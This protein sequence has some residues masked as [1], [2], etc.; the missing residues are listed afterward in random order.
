MYKTTELYMLESMVDKL[1]LI[2]EYNKKINALYD[3]LHDLALATDNDGI[4]HYDNDKYVIGNFYDVDAHEQKTVD[5]YLNIVMEERAE[6]HNIFE[7]ARIDR[8]RKE[9][10]AAAAARKIQQDLDRPYG[11]Q[12]DFYDRT[13][14]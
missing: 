12:R 7:L 8:D 4:S 3:E 13:G 6:R 9:G 11:P 1:K 5:K 14:Q 2:T 10:E